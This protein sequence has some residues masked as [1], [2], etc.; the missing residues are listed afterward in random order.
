MTFLGVQNTRL[1]ETRRSGRGPYGWGVGGLYHLREA[2]AA[3]NSDYTPEKD[4]LRA[5]NTCF[6]NVYP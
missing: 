1:R 2:Q 4:V 3:Y 5:I 6:W